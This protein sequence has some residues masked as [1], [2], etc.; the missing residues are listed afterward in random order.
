MQPLPPNLQA[1]HDK[2]ML[3]NGMKDP[4]TKLPYEYHFV[5]DHRYDL[6]ATFDQTTEEDQRNAA[7]GF[8]ESAF[9]HHSKGRTCYA[10]DASE[11]TPL[12]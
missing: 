8:N 5:N 9:W 3:F 6:C 11:A 10:F 12:P 1:L 4:E 7:P 2:E